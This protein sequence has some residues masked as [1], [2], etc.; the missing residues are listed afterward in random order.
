MANHL[1]FTC[2]FVSLCYIMDTTLRSIRNVPDSNPVPKTGGSD[3]DIALAFLV[4]PNK[5]WDSNS[6]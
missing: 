3:P 4:I 1:N 2:D 5:R 6:K